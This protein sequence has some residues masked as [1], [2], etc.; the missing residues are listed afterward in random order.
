MSITG[1][2]NS[3]PVSLRLGISARSIVVDSPLGSNELELYVETDEANLAVVA[4][5]SVADGFV[6]LFLA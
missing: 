2:A 6:K 5:C 4:D 3:A 1:A